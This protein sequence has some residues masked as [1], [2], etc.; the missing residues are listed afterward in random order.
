MRNLRISLELMLTP[1]LQGLVEAQQAQAKILKQCARLIDEGKLK[2]HLSKT[3]PLE[4]AS[5]AHQLMETGSITGKIVLLIG[6]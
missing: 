2:I 1:M 3:F 5:A 6:S 4:E